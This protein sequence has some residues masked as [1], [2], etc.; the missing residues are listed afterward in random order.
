MATDEINIISKVKCPKCGTL[1]D[2]P[3]RGILRPAD[4]F[5]PGKATY[6]LLAAQSAPMV[7]ACG[8]TYDPRGLEDWQIA[9]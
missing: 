7:C 9:D 6:T 1:V 5:T 8:F 3:F 2:V 4:R